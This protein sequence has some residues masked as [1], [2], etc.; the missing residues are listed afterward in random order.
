NGRVSRLMG[1]GTLDTR[2]DHWGTVEEGRLVQTRTDAEGRRYR[3]E[4]VVDPLAPDQLSIVT[5][6][7]AGV[8]IVRDYRDGQV[9]VSRNGLWIG[10]LLLDGT[11]LPSL[12]LQPA[13]AVPIP[14]AWDAETTGEL[15]HPDPLGRPRLVVN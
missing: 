11:G 2:F 12:L 9:D 5:V 10:G 3:T 15:A 14:S 8:E 4:I 13:G 1:P 6:D 7:P